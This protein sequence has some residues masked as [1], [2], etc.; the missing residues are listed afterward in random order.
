MNRGQQFV[1]NTLGVISQ[2]CM[3]VRGQDEINGGGQAQQRAAIALLTVAG[4]ESVDTV[5]SLKQYETNQGFHKFMEVLRYGEPLFG[6][7]AMEQL[8]DLVTQPHE[9]L[10]NALTTSKNLA[11]VQCIMNYMM[12]IYGHDLVH[13]VATR[14]LQHNEID[15][16][17]R[18]ELK[19]ALDML[20]SQQQTG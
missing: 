8:H 6:R 3:R 9:W 12:H 17:L 5:K 4:P 1:S 16:Q 19:R 2:T 10:H 15:M 18:F 14:M 13:G 20:A 7:Q 11:N